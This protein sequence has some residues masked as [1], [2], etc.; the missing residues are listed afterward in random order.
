MKK[1]V[2]SFQQDFPGMS[3]MMPSDDKVQGRGSLITLIQELEYMCSNSN[4]ITD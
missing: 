1:L 2:V 3:F 4:F